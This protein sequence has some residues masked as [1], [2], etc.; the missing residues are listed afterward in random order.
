VD[1]LEPVLESLDSVPEALR[2]FYQERDGKHV[3]KA[4]VREHPDTLALRR[5]LDDERNGVKTWKQ[6]AA[7][8]EALGMTPAEIAELKASSKGSKG[9]ADDEDLAAFRKKHE[10]EVAAERAR[11]EELER[12]LVDRDIADTLRKAMRDAEVRADD[13]EDELRLNRHRFALQDG[14]VVVLD[15]DGRP[16]TLTVER[17]WTEHYRARKPRVYNGTGATGSGATHGASG[18]GGEAHI[19][20]LP[21]RQQIEAAFAGGKTK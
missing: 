16:D 8:Y 7:E 21:G 17:Y 11:A 10:A 13:I 6:K 12:K 9:K 1:V 14:K 4:N 5:A 18:A 20:T 3:L 19:R 15:E 2:P